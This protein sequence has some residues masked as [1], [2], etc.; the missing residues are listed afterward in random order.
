RA[1]PRGRGL[2]YVYKI[3][4][5][6][7]LKI[8]GENKQERKKKPEERREDEY[9]STKTYYIYNTYTDEYIGELKANSVLDAE[10]KAWDVFGTCT[11][12]VSAF[13]E[14]QG[15]EPEQ[16]KEGQKKEHKKPEIKR[17]VGRAR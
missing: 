12:D 2:V 9:T 10:F 15:K 7:I 11:D 5:E 17:A 16:T 3:Q 4:E 8:T 13:T 6:E 14:K 1:Q